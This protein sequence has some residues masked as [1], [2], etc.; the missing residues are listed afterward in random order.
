MQVFKHLVMFALASFFLAGCVDKKNLPATKANS[1]ISGNDF[2][3]KQVLQ[4]FALPYSEY[5]VFDSISFVFYCSR[6][7]DTSSLIEI[8]KQDELFRAVYYE[9]LP[10]YHRFATDYADKKSKLIFFEESV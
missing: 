4:S 9:T 1:K 2:L 6:S 10:A 5:M 7:Y 3:S 8:K